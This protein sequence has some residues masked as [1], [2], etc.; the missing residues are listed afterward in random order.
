MKK[1][2]VAALISS[3]I[4]LTGCQDK[5]TETKIKQLNQ[6]VAQLT[7]ENV[8]LKEQI[9]KTVPAIF[10]ENEEIFNQSEIIK[11]PKSKEDYQ[12]EETKIEYSISTIKTNIDW[13]NDLLWKKL[14]ENEEMKNISR[15]QFVARYQT[16]FEEDKKEVKETPSF[17]ISHS[18]WTD[19][20]AQKEKLA[21]FAISFYDYEGG[22]HGI[23]G[24]RYFT[25]DLTTRHILILNDLFNEKDLPKVKKLLW[26]QYN[27]SN[28]EYEPVIEADSFNLS[29]N[30]YLDS[31][32]IHFIYDVYEIA[33]YAAGEQDLLL[34]F[35]QLEE[36]FRPEFKRNNYVKFL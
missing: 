12:P 4:L 28:K 18:M 8:K 17:G 9:E 23:E 6:T 26:E 29:N 13:L 24:N 25:I 21:T 36:L 1:T 35:G 31:R 32:G 3:V 15:E 19:F 20:I 33:P 2:L 10:V 5:D 14:T 30:I 22:A 11:H 27:N 7:T 16:A 34:Y